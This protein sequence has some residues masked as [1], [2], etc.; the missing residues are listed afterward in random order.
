MSENFEQAA[1]KIF[2]LA[3]AGQGCPMLDEIRKLSYTDITKAF[4]TAQLL[5]DNRIRT[6]SEPQFPL[7]TFKAAD[8]NNNG[9]AVVDVELLDPARD[10][11]RTNIFHYY[12]ALLGSEDPRC[13]DLK[14]RK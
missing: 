12:N 9:R 1:K 3:Q 7:I 5:E 6:T 4:N 13:K 2:D 11:L 8:T 10:T 14:P